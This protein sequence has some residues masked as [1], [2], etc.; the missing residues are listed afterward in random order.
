MSHENSKRFILIGRKSF[1]IVCEGK[2][3]DGL[4][5]FANG[6]GNKISIGLNKKEVD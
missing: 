5:I 6:R 3:L 2:N 4:R 1:D